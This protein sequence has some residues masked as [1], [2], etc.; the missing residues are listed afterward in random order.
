[1]PKVFSNP[2]Q[3]IPQVDY[4]RAIAS[5]MVATFH[6]GGKSVPVL[7]YGWLGVQ[8]FFVLSGF[9]ICW[10]MP[11]GYNLSMVGKFIYK[12]V[13]RIEPPYIV[14]IGL[15]LVVNSFWVSQYKIDWINV[16]F[17]LGYLN[18]FLGR[19][20]LNPIYWT[21]GVEFQYYLFIALFFPL[22]VKKWGVWVLPIL[23]LIPLLAPIPGTL[24][25]N[26]LSFFALGILYFLYIRGIKS[27][28]EVTLLALFVATIGAF[29]NGLLEITV[30]VIAV[31]LLALP[32]K[33]NS[34]VSFFSKISFSLYLTHDIV[35]SRMVIYLG[36]LLPHGLTSKALAFVC[37]MLVSIAVA[38]AF[39]KLIEEPCFKFSKKI[40]YPLQ[41]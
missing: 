10:A 5:L 6:L 37:G 36:G 15:V 33:N 22:L 9:I 28:L 18:S 31:V 13:I 8:M 19:P 27:L 1:M 7:K 38:Y 12:R 25:F 40:K 17:H 20:G 34:I 24:L 4:I 3:H 29:K 35:G 32:L 16:L 39:Y 41:A 2:K 30:G 26:L 23:C 21:L 14:S 11:E